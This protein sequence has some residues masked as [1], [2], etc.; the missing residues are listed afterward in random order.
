MSLLLAGFLGLAEGTAK[1]FQELNEAQAKQE[2][3]LL[4][5]LREGMQQEQTFLRN[6]DVA[7]A[8]PLKKQEQLGMV[9]DAQSYF[10]DGE[11]FNLPNVAMRG[12]TSAET[13]ANLFAVRGPIEGRSLLSTLSPELPEYKKAIGVLDGAVAEIMKDYRLKG[14]GGA[15]LSPTPIA[16]AI[17]YFDYKVEDRAILNRA[18]Q[19][20][21]NQTVNAASVLQFTP[22]DPEL[23]QFLENLDKPISLETL[24]F[25]ERNGLKTV[26]FRENPDAKELQTVTTDI[27]YTAPNGA[28]RKP[29]DLD[30]SERQ[31]MFDFAS[32]YSKEPS[33]QRARF[34]KIFKTGE[35][36]RSVYNIP[37]SIFV[38]TMREVNRLK[39]NEQITSSPRGVIYGD[40]Q[41][42][43]AMAPIYYR[44]GFKEA[45]DVFN[46]A[47]MTQKNTYYS[48]GSVQTGPDAVQQTYSMSTPIFLENLGLKKADLTR[49]RDSAQQ[50]YVTA[51]DLYRLTTNPRVEG[52]PQSGPVI[53]G[54]LG[55]LDEALLQFQSLGENFNQIIS[56]F[57]TD[58]GSI[59]DSNHYLHG[60]DNQIQ[61]ILN[62][63]RRGGNTL[64]AAQ[65]QNLSR[66]LRKKLAYMFARSLES[67][68]GNA[69][70]SDTDV[71]LAGI[72]QGIEGLL[73][74]AKTAQ[75]VLQYMMRGAL[76]EI[77]YKN[78][79]LNGTMDEMQSAYAIQ[80]VFGT[81]SMIRIS[82][83]I[84]ND[85]NMTAAEAK[86]EIT[87]QIMGGI[88]A[89]GVHDPDMRKD[90][91]EP[92]TP[93]PMPDTTE[94]L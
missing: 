35:E 92:T 71:R 46:A 67:S 43:L 45:T 3:N 93:N 4:S 20:A 34:S 84:L 25:M 86:A 64:K 16:N 63:K 76:K 53:L 77:D 60:V 40:E 80:Q 6:S 48:R 5:R 62:E 61:S 37:T 28:V 82:D 12:T 13:I 70:L 27:I 91:P 54:P 24:D 56:R 39:N 18:L 14:E 66:L 75:V 65:R 47:Y 57:S 15:D 79:M 52:S 17:G 31:I 90:L 58:E 21:A 9:S 8:I 32:N 7:F 42:K 78:I 26:E 30:S 10:M 2:A 73:A 88:Q 68:T 51:F 85:T 69:R 55:V 22:E 38:N 50:L 19:K 29:S 87:R 83:N 1:R 11:N 81:E 33:D 94:R 36:L 23:D 49:S 41:L 72:A 59:N 89:V 44:G 74:N